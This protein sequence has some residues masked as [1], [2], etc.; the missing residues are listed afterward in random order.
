MKWRDGFDYIE[1][2]EICKYGNRF[3]GDGTS[4]AKLGLA[5]H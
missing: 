1:E 2:F 5:L 3:Y 4:E